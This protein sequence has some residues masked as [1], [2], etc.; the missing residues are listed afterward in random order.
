MYAAPGWAPDSRFLLYLAHLYFSDQFDQPSLYA[1]PIDCNR[2]AQSCADSSVRLLPSYRIRAFSWSPDGTML[3]FNATFRNRTGIYLTRL[4]CPNLL[5]NC[6]SEPEL[7]RPIANHSEPVWSPQGTQI[8][9]K[10]DRN[11]MVV[12]D[13]QSRTTR[14]L[15]T[16]AELTDE[17]M[18]TT[19]GTEI[20]YEAHTSVTADLF[21]ID[22]H[23]GVERQLTYSGNE[24]RRPKVRPN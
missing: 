4:I 21:A 22:V 9:Y 19:N 13:V 12:I 24:D 6:I 11:V 10:A 3:A 16:Q 2:S 8:A 5:D 7:L 15:A 18:W 20:I 23:T 17:L 14:Q 1:V